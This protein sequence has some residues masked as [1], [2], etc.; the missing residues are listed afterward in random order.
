ML[1]AWASDDPIL[2]FLAM[3]IA[4][5]NVIPPLPETS[6]TDF[7]RCRDALAAMVE[8]RED[9]EG[10]RELARFVSQLTPPA[11]LSLRFEAWANSLD[12]LTRDSDIYEYKRLNRVRN[13]LLHGGRYPRDRLTLKGGSDVHILSE[14]A[15]RYISV[16]VFGD[17]D[18]FALRTRRPE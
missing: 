14:I 6:Q 13:V 8:M 2:R 10:K 3:F 7:A 18:V 15:A 12:L 17:A 16:A 5:E 4:L 1:R 9:D 11:P